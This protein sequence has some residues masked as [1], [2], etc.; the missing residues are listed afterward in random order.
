MMTQR[1][2]FFRMVPSPSERQRQEM[3][4]DTRTTDCTRFQQY[5][6]TFSPSQGAWSPAHSTRR[7]FGR[8]RLAKSSAMCRTLTGSCSRCKRPPMFIRQPASVDTTVSASVARIQRI[9]ALTMAV[10]TFA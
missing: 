4:H 1:D 7:D 6:D 10:E 2:K 5:V 3:Q 8:Y 9:L